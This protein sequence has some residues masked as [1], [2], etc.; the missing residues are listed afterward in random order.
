MPQTSFPINEIA[1]QTTTKH[2]YNGAC[3]GTLALN[4][5][6][7]VSSKGN[8]DRL[9]IHLNDQ[10]YQGLVFYNTVYPQYF[11][12]RDSMTRYQNPDLHDHIQSSQNRVKLHIS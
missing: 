6:Q 10:S 7:I 5:S 2:V 11:A 8:D 9:S 12:T 1:V 3:D 4:E